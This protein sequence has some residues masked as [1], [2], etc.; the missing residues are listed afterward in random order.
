MHSADFYNEF[1]FEL[2]SFSFFTH[3]HTQMHNI[4]RVL[5]MYCIS[6]SVRVFFVFDFE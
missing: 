5:C 4:H 1:H 6:M 3:I 2:F